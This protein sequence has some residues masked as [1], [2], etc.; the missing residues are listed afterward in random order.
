VRRPPPRAKTS[1]SVGSAGEGENDPMPPPPPSDSK[2]A[3]SRHPADEPEDPFTRKRRR[4]W[5]RLIARTWLEDPETCP[6]CG[7][8]MEVLAAISSPAQDGVI[9]KILRARGEW[10]PPWKRSRKVRGPPPST[11]AS[12]DHGRDHPPE[13]WPEAV[14]PPHPEDHTDPP[15]EDGW[16]G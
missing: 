14:D 7:T 12:R 3:V 13:D 9:E 10:D 8:R 16:E 15:I 4:N 6:R 1:S 11:P 5:A 2:P